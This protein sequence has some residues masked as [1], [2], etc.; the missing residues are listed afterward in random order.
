MTP[1]RVVAFR[2]LAEEAPAFAFRYRFLAAVADEVFRTAD[3]DRF[4]RDEA[5]RVF[6]LRVET[7]RA[8]ECAVVD[9]LLAEEERHEHRRRIARS[10]ARAG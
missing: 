7:R 3:I 10:G 5:L 8:P 6:A 1:R 4:P 9:R 2:R